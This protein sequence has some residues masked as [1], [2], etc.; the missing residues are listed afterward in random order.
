EGPDRGAGDHHLRFLG[1]AI[2][3]DGGDH[4]LPHKAVEAVEQ[5]RAIPG[6]AVTANHGVPG[7]AVARVHLDAPG[8]DEL[9]ERVDDEHALDL[10][11]VTARRR[12][13]DDRAAEVTPPH[14][15][16]IALD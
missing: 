10:L 5:G 4:L 3:P 9:A 12:E 8:V 14:H 15:A 16:H 2:G 6:V 11:R 13:H 7:H 1:V